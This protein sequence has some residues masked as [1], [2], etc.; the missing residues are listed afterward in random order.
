M[1]T[2]EIDLQ[3]GLS[4]FYIYS[5]F[6]ERHGQY[7]G[8]SCDRKSESVLFGSKEPKFVNISNQSQISHLYTL[9]QP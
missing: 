9:S 5:V 1:Y 2:S 6:A 3:V 7:L 4:S 8:K